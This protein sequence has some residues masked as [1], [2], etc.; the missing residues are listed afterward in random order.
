MKKL[1]SLF[2]ALALCLSLSI[3]ASASIHDFYIYDADGETIAPNDV[4]GL[5][6]T[7]GGAVLN[8]VNG[9]DLTLGSSPTIILAP[10]SK[11]TLLRLMGCY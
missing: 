2:L 11:N 1:A 3:P 10:G 8:G 5:S 9:I 7:D 4:P 6:F